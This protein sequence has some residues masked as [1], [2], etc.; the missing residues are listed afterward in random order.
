[1]LRLPLCFDWFA[2]PSCR[3]RP[4]AAGFRDVHEQTLTVHRIWSGTPDE[5]WEYQQEICTIC[6][7]LFDSIPAGLRASIDAGVSTAFS[8]FRSGSVL[9]VPVNVI[10]VAGQRP[11]GQNL[12]A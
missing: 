12:S 9:S 5:L 6:H 7:P 4:E 10:V 8:H 1:M 3:H 11:G 2:T